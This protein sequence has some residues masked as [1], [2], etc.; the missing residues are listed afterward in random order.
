MTQNVFITGAAQGIGRATA[1][2]L[3]DRGW[4]VGA[5]DI[6]DDF[7]WAT[8]P[9]IHTGTLDV[10]DPDAWS[11]AL[12]EFVSAHGGHLDV[13]VNNAGILY[14]GP[15]M[16]EGSY[17]RDSAL[18]D[19]NVKGVLY[20]ARAAHPYLKAQAGS[21][22][23]NIASAAAIYGTPDMAV[24]SA[25]KFAVR[26]ITEALDLEWDQDDI[27]VTSLWPL[28]AQTGM[29]DGV[30]TSGTKRLGVRL[31]ADD[32]ALEV[33]NLVEASRSTPTK[34]HHPVG[35]QAKVMFAAS[36]FSPAFMTRFVNSKLVSDRKIRF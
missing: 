22:L 15:F 28:Y 35:L 7:S 25:T 32:I 34:V 27:T 30:E 18:V 29:L 31:T 24:Y 10:T 12:E 13:L 1:Q 8:H 33:A 26:G 2:L 3:A 9:N 14:G 23:V 5:F 19:V 6:S 20:G 36:H 21:K 16:E 11:T 17:K 4:T